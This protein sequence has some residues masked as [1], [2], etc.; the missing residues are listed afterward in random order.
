MREWRGE[1][2]AA[3]VLPARVAVVPDADAH[4]AG[5]DAVL[6]ESG[7][8]LRVQPERD[9]AEHVLGSRRLGPV[10]LRELHVLLRG[11]VR[12]LPVPE[13]PREPLDESASRRDWDVRYEG[14]ARA[15]LDRSD[16]DLARGQVDRPARR[17]ADGEVLIADD[18]VMDVRLPFRSGETG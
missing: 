10:R 2:V 15:L 5:H 13:R 3:V 9:F 14:A 12:H 4:R 18:P 8:R 16:A 1:S 17:G 6:Q 7:E 11:E